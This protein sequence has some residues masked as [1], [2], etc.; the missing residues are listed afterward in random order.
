[1]G[2]ILELRCGCGT[3]LLR[4]ISATRLCR[5]TIHRV[6]QSPPADTLTSQLVTLAALLVEGEVVALVLV[7][8]LVSV[9][10]VSLAFAV[11]FVG[12]LV[13]FPVA[14]ESGV[15]VGVGAGSCPV[16]DVPNSTVR[17]LIK[18]CWLVGASFIHVLSTVGTEVGKPSTIL[19]KSAV[20]PVRSMA[21]SVLIVC[22]CRL[23][24][25]AVT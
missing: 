5:S 17:V 15:E 21:N 6:A 4:R 3:L 13:A 8:A 11:A 14:V 2:S 7:L 23:G 19:S 18:R 16:A 12:A 1:M 10:V 22:P 24:A 9:G 20:L 25:S